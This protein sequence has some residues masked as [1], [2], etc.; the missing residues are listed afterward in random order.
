[1]AKLLAGAKEYIL[2]VAGSLLCDLELELRDG[3]E[4]LA[5]PLEGEPVLGPARSLGVPHRRGGQ[6]WT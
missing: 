5:G 4:A 2:P 1:M 3:G 6:T